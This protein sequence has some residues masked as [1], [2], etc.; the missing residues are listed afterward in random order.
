[1]TAMPFGMPP[2][3]RTL[4]LDDGH[5]V[6]YY[7]YGDPAGTP[8]VAL[9]GTPAS[10]AGFVWA[11]EPA[12]ARGLRII[13]PD[14]P[15]VGI[16]THTHLDEVADYVP[17]FTATV[18]AL[19][20]EEFA[21][22]G[23]SGGGPYALAAAHALPER[24]HAAAIVAC[25]GQIGVWA[26]TRDFE[27]TDRYMTHLS[28]RVPRVARALL[29]SSAWL[30]RVLPPVSLRFAAIELSRR[31][32]EVLTQFDSA[33]AALALFTR[34]LERGARGVVD[35]YAALGR[36]WGFQVEEVRIPIACWHGDDDRIVPLRHSEDLVA[37]VDGARLVTLPGEGH[38][39]I[40]D[41]V[42]EVL[43]WLAVGRTDHSA[44]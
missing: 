38:L 40:I 9:H 1:M 5:V 20:I 43:D 4:E 35:D 32:R 31:D 39:A 10:G 25:A 15:G 26:R 29:A 34:A 37:R 18:D 17:A 11:D 3:A 14:R 12:R 44:R 16:S 23:Y 8:V 6:G 21:L 28:M 19:G 33:T 41:H 24:V 2:S 22:L 27:T 7:E 13:A 30:S 36:P 42:D